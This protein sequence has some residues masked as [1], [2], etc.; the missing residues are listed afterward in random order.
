MV[1]IKIKRGM[2]INL[3]GEP[4]PIL[5]DVESSPSVCLYPQEIPGIKPKIAVKEGDTVKKGSPLFYDKRNSELQFLSPASGT[6]KSVV[7]GER[8]SL[9]QII[10]EVDHKEPKAETF[11]KFTPK[12]ICSLDRETA[13]DHLCKTGYLAHIQ[14]RPFSKIPDL[15]K[16]PKSIFVNGMNTAP[17]QANIHVAVQGEEPAFQAGIKVL[18]RLTDGQVHLCLDAQETMSAP[19]VTQVESAEVHYFI[20]PHPT[21]NSSVHIHHIDPISPGDTVWVVR[22]VDL[23]LIG[24]LFLEGQLPDKKIVAVGGPCVRNE[25]RKHYR[26]QIGSAISQLLDGQLTNDECRILSGDALSGVSIT[27][28]GYLPWSCTS[29][30]VI[31]ESEQRNLLGWLAPGLKRYSHS[32]LFLS[33]WFRG[34]GSWTLNTN[35]N[36]SHRAMVLTGLYDRFMPMN[37]KVDFLVRAVL[38][39]D[40]EEAVQLGILETDPEDFAL[41]SFACPSKMDLVGIVERGLQEIEEEGL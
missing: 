17:F 25:A 6:V 26:V 16:A 40:T 28:E 18:T 12:E 5:V 14:Q 34:G 15:T 30:T 31:P 13:I 22:A 20:G 37:I 1:P 9:Q 10:V 8:R 27:K 3:A 38:A 23:L 2:D 7:L 35:Q 21:G 33:T 36:G 39:H 24:K 11:S 32:R 19:A 29:L 4:S 41:C